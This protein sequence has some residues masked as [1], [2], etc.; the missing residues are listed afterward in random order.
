MARVALDTIPD[1]GRPDAVVAVLNEALELR[2]RLRQARDELVAATA[3]LERQEAADVEAAAKAIRSG[4]APGNL[5]AKVTKQRHAVEVAQRNAAALEL[6][7]EAAE[8]DLAST[9]LA[10]ADTW[11]EE[12]HRDREQARER[13]VAALEHFEAAAL[14]VSRAAGAEAW[15]RSATTDQRFDRPVP[16]ML[17]GTVAPSSR[18]V[19]ANSEPLHVDALIGWLREALEPPTPTPVT[20]VET[21]ETA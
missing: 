17:V 12:L 11:A 2:G 4:E 15:L 18:R 14:E 5:S 13:A 19:T 20:L 1:L 21:A 7:S 8:A 16:A 6:A 3:E 10:S 9:M